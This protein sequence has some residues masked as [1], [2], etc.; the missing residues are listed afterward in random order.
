MK[1]I[2]LI[3]LWGIG[4]IELGH[5]QDDLIYI[6]DGAEFT[7]THSEILQI[8][9]KVSPILLAIRSHDAAS[10]LESLHLQFDLAQESEFKVSRKLARRQMQFA[11]M[12]ADSKGI[13]SRSIIRDSYKNPDEPG[14]TFYEDEFQIIYEKDPAVLETKVSMEPLD[15]WRKREKEFQVLIF[16]SAAK[17][18]A[19]PHPL[20]GAGHHSVA[21]RELYG[22]HAL[23]PNIF[24]DAMAHPELATHV[25][26][27]D[28]DADV[29]PLVPDLYKDLAPHIHHLLTTL[30][31]LNSQPNSMK[32]LAETMK[33][34][35]SHLH[36]TMIV[37]KGGK[38]AGP[39]RLEFRFFL[40]Q[41]N[42]GE[43]IDQGVFLEQWIRGAAKEKTHREG[44]LNF[45]VPA[46]PQEAAENFVLLLHRREIDPVH[47]LKIVRPKFAPFLRAALERH[48]E[49]FPNFPRT[50]RLSRIFNRCRNF[51]NP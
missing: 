28:M 44:V 15:L 39:Y 14:F 35:N 9:K 34:Y 13:P 49:L 40:A 46:T 50:T 4:G 6:R 16:D 41:E 22:P 18:G 11:K 36:Q 24:L 32:K 51:F 8:T 33:P 20:Y 17:V 7:F 27:D 25:F 30:Y 19:F 47:T 3:V 23:I 37:L 42:V 1:R 12:L 45:S 2:A 31:Q 38:R 5:A 29:M 48:P 43:F 21:L 26:V 10:D